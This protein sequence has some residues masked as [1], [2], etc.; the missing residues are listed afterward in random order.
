MS[1]I[2]YFDTLIKPRTRGGQYDCDYLNF[3]LFTLKG[4]T[5]AVKQPSF[6]SLLSNF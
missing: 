1:L 5:A 6:N 3:F 2:N 4:N